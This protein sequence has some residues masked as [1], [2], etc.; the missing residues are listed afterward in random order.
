MKKIFLIASACFFI[1]S[2]N[3]L[4]A[5][6]NFIVTKGA[7]S[8]LYLHF[9]C[10]RSRFLYGELSIGSSTTLLARVGYL[11]MD[12]GKLG[13]IKQASVAYNVGTSMNTGSHFE[14]T[15]GG[16]II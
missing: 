10:C 8:G 2:Q 16:L 11:R 7:K 14:T 12:S 13:Q 5:C 3:K 1:F 15:C 4:N 9:L 6:T